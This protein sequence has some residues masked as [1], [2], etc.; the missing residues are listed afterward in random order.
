MQAYRDP[1]TGEFTS[2]PA[3]MRA[4]KDPATGEFVTPPPGA[5]SAAPTVGS[6]AGLVVQPGAGRAS[7]PKAFRRADG[8]YGVDMRGYA[9]TYTRAVRDADGNLTIEHL[10]GQPPVTIQR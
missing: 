2:P 3:A 1:K 4:H 7:K 9:R 5:E 6:A 10:D 8:S